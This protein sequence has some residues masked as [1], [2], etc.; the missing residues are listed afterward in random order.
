MIFI[1][2]LFIQVSRMWQN[3]ARKKETGEFQEDA[4]QEA[5]SEEVGELEVRK[6][7]IKQIQRSKRS[8]S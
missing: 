4:G 7:R 6:H 3:T 1:V 5:V 8:S 2:L